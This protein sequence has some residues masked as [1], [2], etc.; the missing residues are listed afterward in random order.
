[1][2]PAMP[3]TVA[4][5]AV[6]ASAVARLGHCRRQGQGRQGE[7]RHLRRARQAPAQSFHRRPPFE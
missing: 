2:S 5:S 7:D 4:A 6:A 3:A 1:M